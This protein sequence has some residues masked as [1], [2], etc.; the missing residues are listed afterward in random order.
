MNSTIEDV[1]VLVDSPFTDAVMRA[2]GVTKRFEA[3]GFE[4]IRPEQSFSRVAEADESKMLNQWHLLISKGMGSACMFKT[5]E[6]RRAELDAI[7]E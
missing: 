6:V 4:T 3:H 2:D 5:K 7:L 1:I